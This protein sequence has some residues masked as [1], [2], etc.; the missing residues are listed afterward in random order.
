[1]YTAVALPFIILTKPTK[2]RRFARVRL[3][4]LIFPND[5]LYAIAYTGSDNDTCF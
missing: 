1:M 3:Y 4:K 5:F 2:R